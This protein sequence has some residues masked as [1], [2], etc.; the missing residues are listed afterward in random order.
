MK[1]LE[2]EHIQNCQL[3]PSRGYMLSYIKHQHFRHEDV[4]AVELGVDNGVFSSTIL[5]A[6]E[7]KDLYLVDTWASSRYSQTKEQAVRQAVKDWN[8]LTDHHVVIK[9][10]DS[11]K[12]AEEFEDGSVHFVYIDTVHD[13]DTTRAELEAWAP[14]LAPNGILAG[15]DYIQGNSNGRV[16]YGVIEA[17]A[18]FCNTHPWELIYLTTEMETH[19]SFALQRRGVV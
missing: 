10:M 4:K 9:K 14:K 5:P 17:V 1:E 6:L 8:K 2:I 13:Y 11:I 3:L 16:K 12:A 19:P 15:H 18:D 7:P